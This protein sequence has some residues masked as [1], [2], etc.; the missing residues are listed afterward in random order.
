VEVDT[1]SS[2]R[3]CVPPFRQTLSASGQ[4]VSCLQLTRAGSSQTCLL[5]TRYSCPSVINDSHSTLYSRGLPL[6]FVSGTRQVT[7]AD[8]TVQSISVMFSCL[9]DCW[10]LSDRNLLQLLIKLE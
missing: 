4:P 5:V 10:Y 1:T 7:V 6:Q 2:F 3:S 9:S 8:V